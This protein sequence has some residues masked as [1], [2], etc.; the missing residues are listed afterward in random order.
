MLLGASA[1]DLLA[2]QE[3]V[4]F[5]SEDHDASALA[6]VAEEDGALEA[7]SPLARGADVYTSPAAV[8]A[9]FPYLAPSVAAALHTR[10]GRLE[11][12]ALAY[13]HTAARIITQAIEQCG[14]HAQRSLY[15]RAETR[16][17]TVRFELQEEVGA[18]PLM[19]SDWP[20]MA[21]EGF[22][23]PLVASDDL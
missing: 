7:A 17:G 8:R 14:A 1:Q 9:A 6:S 20:L 15:E 12:A 18:T 11:D 21:S 2:G 5:S 19:A 13:E 23:W 10:N 22:W 4:P 3:E 16:V